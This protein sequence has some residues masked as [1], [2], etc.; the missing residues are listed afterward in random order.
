MENC[1]TVNIP[2]AKP[3]IIK[4]SMEKK[5]KIFVKSEFWHPKLVIK[6]VGYR[7]MLITPPSPPFP[8][9]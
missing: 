4:N 1:N 3:R 9:P 5:C 2:S 8:H 7:T 6:Q